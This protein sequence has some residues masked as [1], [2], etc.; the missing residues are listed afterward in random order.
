MKE[1]TYQPLMRQHACLSLSP[2]VRQSVNFLGCRSDVLCV[3]LF[4]AFM[5]TDM[6]Y[7]LI[8]WSYAFMFARS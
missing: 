8:F 4:D 1:K 7:I 2:S 6:F 3:Y 5:P